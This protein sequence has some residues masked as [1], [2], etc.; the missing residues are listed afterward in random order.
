MPD[1]IDFINEQLKNHRF[2]Y[3]SRGIGQ[4]SKVLRRE[5]EGNEQVQGMIDDLEAWLKK[6]F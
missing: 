2:E 6:E 5:Y 1:F 4:L 3:S